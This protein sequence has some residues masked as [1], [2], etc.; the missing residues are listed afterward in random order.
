M[1]QRNRHLL[2]LINL[3]GHSQTGYFDALPVSNIEVQVSGQFARAR[4][5]R[6]NQPLNVR[7]GARSTSFILPALQQY[8]LIVLE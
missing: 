4:A 7:P 1:K 5:L 6:S 2:H 8:E 3:T